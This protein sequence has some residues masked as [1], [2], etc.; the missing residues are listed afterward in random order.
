MKLRSVKLMDALLQG[1]NNGSLQSDH[2]NTRK[3]VRQ[4]LLNHADEMITENIS[5]MRAFLGWTIAP[6]K[7]VETY[8]DEIQVKYIRTGVLFKGIKSSDDIYEFLMQIFKDTVDHREV[9]VATFL[10][11]RNDVLGYFVV[12]AGGFNSTTADPKLIFQVALKISASY[13][14]LAHNHPS[15]NK[16][17]SEADLR[18]TRKLGEG[19]RLLEMRVIDHLIVTSD[20]YYSFADESD[21]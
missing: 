11:G 13:I 7:P 3:R 6:A 8:V 16:S 1:I 19:A 4:F 17:P 9:F 20:G 18:M 14:I 5:V 10:N 12:G 2:D 15:G 21:L